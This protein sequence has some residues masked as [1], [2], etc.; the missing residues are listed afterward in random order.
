MTIVITNTRHCLYCGRFIEYAGKGQPRRYCD[1]P[2]KSKYLREKHHGPNLPGV[3]HICPMDGVRFFAAQPSARYC[4][5]R[6]RARARKLRI[7]MD[8]DS[9]IEFNEWLDERGTDES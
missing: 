5:G 4:S 1:E 8:I 6:C 9:I 7:S 3:E 2:H